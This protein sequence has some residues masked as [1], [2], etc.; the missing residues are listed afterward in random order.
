MPFR[1][2]R[3]PGAQLL[4][5]LKKRYGPRAT[6]QVHH[7]AGLV[8]ALIESKAFQHVARETAAALLEA[9]LLASGDDAVTEF[10]QNNRGWIAEALDL[11]LPQG[12]P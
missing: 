3:P 12:P 2:R 6:I 4:H 8:F 11:L 7:L 1:R 10:I 5:D 9:Y